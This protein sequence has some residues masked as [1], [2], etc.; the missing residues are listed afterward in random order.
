VHICQ[1]GLVVQRVLANVLGPSAARALVEIF[2]TGRNSEDGIP[3]VWTARTGAPVL[4][5]IIMTHTQL[6][7]PLAMFTT[8]KDVTCEGPRSIQ[9][10][11][12]NRLTLLCMRG[13]FFAGP[14][15]PRLRNR[16]A[17]SS[18]RCARK[19]PTHPSVAADCGLYERVVSFYLGP[20]W[21]P[22]SWGS[23]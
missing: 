19:S 6:R 18:D 2:S 8:D 16:V 14:E 20:S 11:Y 15:A 23:R 4:L 22:K 10:R 12:W 9:V 7:F 17:S 1:K 5:H 13:W 3:Q 21:R